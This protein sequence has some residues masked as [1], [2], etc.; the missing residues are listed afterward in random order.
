M[1]ANKEV[2]LAVV[3]A[4]VSCD[5]A[6]LGQLLEA[7]AN[8]HIPASS[9][10]AGLSDVIVGRDA[11]VAMVEMAHAKHYKH[12]KVDV[13]QVVGEDDFVVILCK[14]LI[15]AYSSKSLSNQYVYF[16]RLKDGLV[17]EA[18]ELTDTASTFEL[19]AA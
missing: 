1:R 15:T 13:E 8:W 11:I 3:N 10:R 14:M 7:K 6:A 16:M 12:L 18:W 4:M 17:A 9:K 2:A 5:A 19:L